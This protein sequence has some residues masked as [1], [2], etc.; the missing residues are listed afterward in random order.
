[1][2][3]GNMGQ[4]AKWGQDA[5]ASFVF[6][7]NLIV[8]NCNRMSAALPGAAQNFNMTTGLGGSYLSNYC[9]AA[10][11]LFAYFAGPGSS[12]TIANNSMVT[13][14]PTMFDL[15]CNPSGA[16]GSTPYNFTDNVFL[17]YT[18]STSYYP[19]SGESPGLYYREDTSIDTVGSHN[20]E[21]GVRNGDCQSGS[22]GNICTDPL[23]VN[24]PP[25]GAVPPETALDGFDFKPSSASP[26]IKAGSTYA[27]QSTTDYDGAA[28]TSPPTIGAI[29][30]AP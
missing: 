13:Y 29:V 18:T 30:Y 21:Y 27:G 3:I 4:S 26:A 6:E 15:S 16:C 23:F 11:D 28:Q 8:G 25:Q 14:Q 5:N 12:V 1:V 17:G 2:W 22:S 9:R 20:V 10:G 7:N 24:E 19:S